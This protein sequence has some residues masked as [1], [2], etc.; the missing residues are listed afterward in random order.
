MVLLFIVR[1]VSGAGIV[2]LG[3][4]DALLLKDCIDCKSGGGDLVPAVMFEAAE[5][6][7]P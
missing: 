2:K 3:G 7:D 6:I 4:Y 5:P 1:G